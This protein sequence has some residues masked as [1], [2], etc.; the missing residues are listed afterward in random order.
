M[1]SYKANLTKKER[2][3]L[4]DLKKNGDHLELKIKECLDF[5]KL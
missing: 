1:I 4:M 3:K 5:I 2:E